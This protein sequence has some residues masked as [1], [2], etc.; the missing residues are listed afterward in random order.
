MLN[1]TSLSKRGMRGT[2]EGGEGG[3]YAGVGRDARFDGGSTDGAKT[4][5]ID[6]APPRR[7][8]YRNPDGT[9]AKGQHFVLKLASQWRVS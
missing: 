9:R 4:F 8:Y 1:K 7:N 2:G 3:G 5:R 6:G